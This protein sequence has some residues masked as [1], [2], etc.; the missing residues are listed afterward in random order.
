MSG[1]KVYLA[2]PYVARDALRQYADELRLIGMVCTSSWLTEDVEIK[3]GTIG[4]TVEQTED[5]VQGHCK[6]DFADIDR[7]NVLV[8]FTGEVVRTSMALPDPML[9]SQLHTGGRHVETGYALAKYKPVI[10]IGPAENV[11]HRGACIRAT[12]W[13]C[14]VLA[15]INLDR[16]LP[17]DGTYADVARARRAVR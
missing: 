17:V 11:F 7:A 9:S 8:V 10:V 6:K 2:A 4:A 5:Q 16:A 1:L 3:Q 14:A 12:N 15:L 13:H